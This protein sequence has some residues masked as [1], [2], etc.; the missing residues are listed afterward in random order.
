[1]SKKGKTDPK[2]PKK[3]NS[4]PAPNE[5]N[6]SEGDKV[7]YHQLWMATESLTRNKQLRNFFQLERD[8]INAFWQITKK[9][10]ESVK[11]EIRNKDRQKEEML[12]RHQVEMKVY[13]QKLRHLLYEQKVQVAELKTETERGLKNKLEEHREKEADLKKDKRE[14]KKES[15]GQQ[16]EHEDLLYR[17]QQDNDKELTLQMQNFERNMKEMQMKYDRRIKNLRE[18]MEM[19]RKAEI[20]EIERRKTD[21]IRELMAEHDKA[22]QDIRD[23]YNDITSNNLELIKNYKEQVST[24]KRNEAYSEKLMFEIAQENRRLTEPLTKALKEVN[25]LRHELATYEKDK[26]S[27]KNAKQRL[28]LLEQQYKTLAWE[29]E[30]L[31]Q[32]YDKIKEERD[33]LYERFQNTLHEF[34]QKAVF[35]NVIL[36]K[37]MEILQNQLEKKDAQLGEILKASN[38]EPGALIQVERKLD[39]LVS[40]KNA[41]IEELQVALAEITQRHDKLV[42]SY[43]SYL[44]EHGVAGL[45]P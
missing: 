14:I 6:Q 21:H 43:E 38:I 11:A 12:E 32:R 27:L 41:T 33:K 1:M 28:M 7:D 42:N 17:M 29:H 9:E 34:Q 30:V 25:L 5:A 16:L 22:F 3:T 10:L 24:M 13:K 45:L 35:K 37:K 18:E 31:Q 40:N 8:K 15:K 19:K 26:Q 23:Y 39:E 2:S 36:H 4:D 44:T 20:D